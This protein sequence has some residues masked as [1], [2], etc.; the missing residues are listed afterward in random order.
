[1]EFQTDKRTVLS[2]NSQTESSQNNCKSISLEDGDGRASVTQLG[3][4]QGHLDS[5]TF[6][7]LYVTKTMVLADFKITKNFS[8]EIIKVQ[9][10]CKHRLNSVKRNL[11]DES[12]KNILKFILFFHKSI[13]QS[14]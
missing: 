3:K 1:M 13:F 12:L 2:Q 7:S 8:E 4:L 5:I 10:R 11:K 14:L 6:S 9:W